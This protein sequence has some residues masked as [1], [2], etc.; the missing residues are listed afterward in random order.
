MTLS[1]SLTWLPRKMRADDGD[2]GDERKNE[3]IFGQSLAVVRAADA[4][5]RAESCRSND[6]RFTSFPRGSPAPEDG[7][8]AIRRAIKAGT[9]KVGPPVGLS[10]ARTVGASRQ[11]TGR[12]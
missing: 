8:F 12:I 9:S 3:C 5:T 7:L 4:F 11:R 10:I 2:D 6:I 1:L